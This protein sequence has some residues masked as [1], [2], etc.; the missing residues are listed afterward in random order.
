MF[1][2]CHVSCAILSTRPAMS[3][4]LYQ[5]A[6]LH[7]PSTK[8]QS[9]QTSTYENISTLF[10]YLTE[11]TSVIECVNHLRE[12]INQKV[13]LGWIHVWVKCT[14]WSTLCVIFNYDSI[15][16][17]WYYSK[18]VNCSFVL[19]G[20]KSVSF[21]V[22]SK[23]MQSCEAEE[24]VLCPPDPYIPLLHPSS[25]PHST[26][27]TISLITALGYSSFFS[28]YFCFPAL[29]ISAIGFW[30]IIVIYC[31]VLVFQPEVGS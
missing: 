21:L 12:K 31:Q 16:L 28:F 7:Y 5:E 3:A 30:N 9:N 22:H 2:R 20:W 19:Y 25:Y 4:L 18:Q 11:S 17:I 24:S 10:N 29:L 23:H 6:I 15:A 1:P 13:R 14:L 27:S 26:G 8:I